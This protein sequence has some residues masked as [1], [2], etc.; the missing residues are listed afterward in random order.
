MKHTVLTRNP[1]IS[2]LAAL[3]LLKRT[4]RDTELAEWLLFRTA[5]LTKQRLVYGDLICVYCGKPG[6]LE[7]GANNVLATIDHIHPK[8][9]GGSKY[10]ESN[11]A[12]ACFKC[13]QKKGRQIGY[14]KNNM[15]L[16]K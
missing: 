11:L 13:N 9:E 14:G 15:L 6:L 12:V 5:Y 3:V 8:C 2:S 10:D 7:E 4:L 1:H 16:R